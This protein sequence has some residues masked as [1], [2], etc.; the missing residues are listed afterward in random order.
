MTLFSV[1]RFHFFFLC[2]FVDKQIKK[3]A[4]S[5]KIISSLVKPSLK[6]CA[7]INVDKIFS[8][9]QI[10]LD[11]ILAFGLLDFCFFIGIRWA[12]TEKL[13]NTFSRV[14]CF[15]VLSKN[16][17]TTTS[18]HKNIVE[19]DQTLSVHGIL[20]SIFYWVS[21]ICS[22]VWSSES[23]LR[24]FQAAGQNKLTSISKQR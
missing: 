7:T 9:F 17:P 5:K 23:L 2:S 20:T 1:A 24:E 21:I 11:R 8:S 16:K 18:Y 12:L 4:F 22:E 10:Q 14:E 15:E 3:M 19:F 13:V 6:Q